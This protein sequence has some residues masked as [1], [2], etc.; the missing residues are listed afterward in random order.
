MTHELTLFIPS[1]YRGMNLS[2]PSNFQCWGRKTGAPT[3]QIGGKKKPV[4]SITFNFCVNE[5]KCLFLML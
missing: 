2:G 4:V 1:N 5:A 3:K